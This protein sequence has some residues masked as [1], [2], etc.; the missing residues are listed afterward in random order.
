MATELDS[1]LFYKEKPRESAGLC[2]T[3]WS[4]PCTT[5]PNIKSL[6]HVDTRTHETPP[7]PPRQLSA[8]LLTPHDFFLSLCWLTAFQL[9]WPAVTLCF[10]LKHLS[11]SPHWIM[12]TNALCC[13]TPFLLTTSKFLIILW[14][15]SALPSYS[16]GCVT[17][18]AMCSVPRIEKLISGVYQFLMIIWRSH[19]I[20]MV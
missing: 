7:Q 9:W 13:P 19:S 4:L 14:C 6:E 10:H 17:A 3:N 15:V 18:H 11:I 1:T 8:Q 5:K 2:S 16:E 20:L 12:N